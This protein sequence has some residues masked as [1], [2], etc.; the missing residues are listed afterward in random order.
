[1][2]SKVKAV[3][4]GYHTATPYLALQDTARAIDFYKQVFGAKEL[5][6]MNAPDGKVSHAE[7]KIGDSVLMLSSAPPSTGLQTPESIGGSTVSI[8]LYLEDVDTVFNRAVSAG[9][10]VIQA[11]ANQFWGD[12]YGRLTDPFG[13]CWSL[14]TH[15]EDVAPEEMGRRAQE[16]AAKAAK[17]AQAGG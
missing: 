11:P 15:I 8:F 9:S 2:T 14:A 3:P 7:I 17:R 4:E 12:R 10:K 6:R 16:L 1:M 5:M 13:H